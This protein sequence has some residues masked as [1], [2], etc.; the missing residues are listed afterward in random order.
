MWMK[1]MESGQSSRDD[2]PIWLNIDA[3]VSMKRVSA[4]STMLCTGHVA[5]DELDEF[6]IYVRET[7]E[8]IL[9]KITDREFVGLDS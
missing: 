5:G 6:R 3:F 9:Q 2:S 8:E 1:L 4:L 7:P